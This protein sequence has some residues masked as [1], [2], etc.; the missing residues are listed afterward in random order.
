MQGIENLN[1][2]QYLDISENKITDY[3]PLYNLKNLKE[4]TTDYMNATQLKDLQDKL[5]NTKINK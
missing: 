5:P 2:L 1:Q 3:K 4:L